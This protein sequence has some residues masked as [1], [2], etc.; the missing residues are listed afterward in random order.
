MKYTR[1]IIG[2]AAILLT[3]WVIVGEQ[4]TAAS[5][6][7]VVNAPVVTLRSPIA[8]E[9]ELQG[10][11]LGGRLAQD[12]LL[13]TISDPR[14]DSTRLN[15]LQFELDSVDAENTRLQGEISALSKSRDALAQRTAAF[16]SARSEELEAE[17]A[18]AKVRVE[19]LESGEADTAATALA[20]AVQVEQSRRPGEPNTRDLALSHARERVQTLQIALDALQSGVF[21]GDGYNDAPFSEQRR[22]QLD[23]EIAQLGSARSEA[24]ARRAALERRIARARQTIGLNSRVELRAPSREMLY[25]EV[26]QADTVD[27]QR[28]DPVLRLVDCGQ[29]IVTLSV[30]ERVF[31]TLRVGQDASF[32]FTGQSKLY[33]ATVGRLAGSGARTVYANLAIAPSEKHLERYDVTLLV[34]DLNADAEIGCAVGRTGRAFFDGRPLDLFRGWF[35]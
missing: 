4:M 25:W 33:P 7:A 21:L 18:E 23:A 29:S 16:T 6:N 27:V 12:E 28:G 24:S 3:L 17:L 2:I 30:T 8:G 15:D 22:I 35:D 11:A 20:D 13:A 10:H 1:L 26:L 32:R 31:N 9:I 5:A 14:A 34:P 19:L